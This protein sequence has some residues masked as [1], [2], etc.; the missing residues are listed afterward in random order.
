M[1][2]DVGGT[3]GAEKKTS[4]NKL[5]FLNQMKPVPD[6]EGDGYE[7]MKPKEND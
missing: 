4:W 6:L 2:A 5:W 1:M 3:Q 7:L